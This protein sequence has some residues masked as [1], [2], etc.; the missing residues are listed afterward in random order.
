MWIILVEHSELL[1]EAGVAVEPAA[2][3]PIAQFWLFEPPAPMRGDDPR[4]PRSA[5]VHI[6]TVFA[7]VCTV[8]KAAPLTRETS[9]TRWVDTCCASTK[10][11]LAD[12]VTVSPIALQ[13]STSLPCADLAT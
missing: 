9:A 13:V 3:T 4:H 8:G 10:H 7:G 11:A 12:D 2:L 6:K 1:E 5:D